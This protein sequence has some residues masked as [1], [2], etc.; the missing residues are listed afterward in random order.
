MILNDE[1]LKDKQNKQ[2]VTTEKRN[3][4][5]HFTKIMFTF[6]SSCLSITLQCLVWK[7][8]IDHFLQ[9]L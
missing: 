1:N 3:I 9:V 5:N 8:T 4:S 6:T 2:N 7:Q